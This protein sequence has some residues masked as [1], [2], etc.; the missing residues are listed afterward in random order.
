VKT[1]L[2]LALLLASCVPISASYAAI[3]RIKGQTKELSEIHDILAEALGYHK[4]AE[5]DLNSPC[6]GDYVTGAHTAVTLAMEAAST[7]ESLRT[8]GVAASQ[9]TELQRELAARRRQCSCAYW[10]DVDQLMPS[11]DCP[12]HGVEAHNKKMQGELAMN[13]LRLL[14]RILLGESDG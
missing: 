2:G 14:R 8:N 1:S 11:P 13:E 3:L 12:M 6:P 4:D 9:I 10:S 5:D 7:L